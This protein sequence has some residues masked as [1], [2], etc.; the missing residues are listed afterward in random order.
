MTKEGHHT[1]SLHGQHEPT[2]RDRIFEDFRTGRCKVLITTN[3]LAR[4][5]DIQQV[6]LVV[7]YDLPVMQDTG[8][9]DYETY[10]HRVGRTGRFGRTGVA[11]NFVA[12]KKD[13][14]IVKLIQEYF[15]R[16]ILR[17]PADDLELLEKTLRTAGVK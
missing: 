4:G 11:I 3:V 10:L 5:I 16:K 14:E 13:Y 2:E 1:T 12:S 7:N 6:N 15:G 17:L 9:P 8:L